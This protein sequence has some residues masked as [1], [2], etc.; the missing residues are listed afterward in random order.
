MRKHKHREYL[1]GIHL[2]KSKHAKRFEFSIC[3]IGQIIFARFLG[4]KVAKLI[5]ES[6]FLDYPR[7]KA[8]LPF[9]SGN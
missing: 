3:G 1:A 2:C 8:I 4:K 5:I 9:L 7:Y 6:K